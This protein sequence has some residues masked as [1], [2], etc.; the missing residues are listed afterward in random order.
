MSKVCIFKFLKLQSVQNSSILSK[1][2]FEQI[3]TM[4]GAHKLSKIW[5][6]K[7][8]ILEVSVL[9]KSLILSKEVFDQ[10][11]TKR[12][13][14]KMSTVC[15]CKKNLQKAVFEKSYLPTKALFFQVFQHFRTENCVADII[16]EAFN[17][18]TFVGKC[19]KKETWSKSYRSYKSVVLSSLSAFQKKIVLPT[20][21]LKHLNVRLLLA[22]VVKSGR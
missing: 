18:K 4:R 3:F 17:C 15:L 20:S 11:F 1:H 5:L 16:N 13:A 19:C 21:L 22:N 10:F 7:F 14:H 12:E 8:Q 6:I 2:V 9:S